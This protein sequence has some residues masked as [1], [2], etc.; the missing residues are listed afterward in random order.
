MKSLLLNAHS[1]EDV[2]DTEGDL[3]FEVE[4]PEHRLIGK[5]K[6]LVSLSMQNAPGLNIIV[7]DGLVFYGIW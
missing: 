6:V 2:E 7:F 1:V 3:Y 4:E 5:R